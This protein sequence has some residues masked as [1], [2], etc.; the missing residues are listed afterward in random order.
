M[1]E[2]S[3][4]KRTQLNCARESRVAWRGGARG[5]G[6]ASDE[7]LVHSASDFLDGQRFN[8]PSYACVEVDEELGCSVRVSISRRKLVQNHEEDRQ[9]EKD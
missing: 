9:W 1:S 5:W 3:K 2:E 4:D 8:V 7:K 6:E